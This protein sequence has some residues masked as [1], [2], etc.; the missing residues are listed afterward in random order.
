MGGGGPR[1]EACSFCAVGAPQTADKLF[2]VTDYC[3]GGELFFHLKKYVA[4]GG[5]LPAQ[6]ALGAQ[7]VCSYFAQPPECGMLGVVPAVACKRWRGVHCALCVLH[8]SFAPCRLRT[9]T[10]PMVQFF[11]AELVAALNHLHEQG[12]IYRDLKP[13]NVLLD[14]VCWC[15]MK[16]GVGRRGRG[17]GTHP[18]LGR[19]AGLPMWRTRMPRG[20]VP[21]P[22]L[23]AQNGH[24]HITDFGLSKDD[25][26]SDK[27][28]T[29]FCGTPEYLAPEM[30]I[31]RKTREGYGKAVDWCVGALCAGGVRSRGSAPAPAPAPCVLLDGLAH[32]AAPQRRDEA[33]ASS[34]HAACSRLCRAAPGALLYL[35]DLSAAG[36]GPRAVH[37]P[38]LCPVLRRWS[39]GTL[40]YEMLTGWPPF[41]DKNVRK[42]CDQILR[43]RQPHVGSWPHLHPPPLHPVPA[44][45]HTSGAC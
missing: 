12:V 6:A 40:I 16:A 5:R 2:M 21:P 43:V 14:E 10:E 39:L 22:P 44:C 20:V 13:E 7:R 3:R 8:P 29:T 36:C 38:P 27:G 9:F 35:K 30:L 34:A 26:A 33:Q 45:A 19:K 31:N 32:P 15:T 1:S 18:T 41:Y 42:M 37:V 28:A 17:S 23:P 25:V 11:A 24:I 4:G